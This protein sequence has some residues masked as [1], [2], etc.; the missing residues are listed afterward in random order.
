MFN[1]VII[2]FDAT[3]GHGLIQHAAAVSVWPFLQADCTVPPIP[4]SAVHF[5]LAPRN[6][7]SV[8]AM[9]AVNIH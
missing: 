5:Q 3:T 1:G 6:F 2:S 8:V 9:A 4:G 7:G